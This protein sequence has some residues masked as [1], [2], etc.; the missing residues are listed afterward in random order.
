MDVL[1]IKPQ[2][3]SR[4]LSGE[5]LVEVRGSRTSKTG[6]RIG[7]AYSKSGCVYGEATLK[8]IIRFDER[9]WEE[10]KWAHTVN[11]SFEEICQRYKQPWGWI[12]LEPELYPEPKRY[13]HPAGAVI[14]VSNAIFLEDM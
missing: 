2:H 7:I 12:M 3:G 11:C 6:E 4:I 9:K 13:Y 1:I 8:D 14:W 5:K 10:F